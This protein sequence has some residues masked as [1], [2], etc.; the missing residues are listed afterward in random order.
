[1]LPVTSFIVFGVAAFLLLLVVGVGVNDVAVAV[2]VAVPVLL[3][4]LQTINSES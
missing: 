4:R 3:V 2:A 1:M